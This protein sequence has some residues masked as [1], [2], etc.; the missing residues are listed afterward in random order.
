MKLSFFRRFF[1]T[2]RKNGK[3][4]GLGIFQ[5]GNPSFVF[6]PFAELNKNEGEKP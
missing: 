5:D 1:C 4:G 6:M 2:F 3:E